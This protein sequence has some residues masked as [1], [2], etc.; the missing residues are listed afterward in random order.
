MDKFAT[1]TKTYKHLE[2]PQISLLWIISLLFIISAVMQM[3]YYWVVFSRFAFY[4]QQTTGKTS[5]PVS[6]VISAKNEFPN[7]KANLP[8]ILE[9]AYPEFEVVVVNDASDDETIFLLEDLKRDYTHLKIVNIEL[10]TLELLGLRSLKSRH[11]QAPLRVK[12]ICIE[13]GEVPE[14]S[15]RVVRSNDEPSSYI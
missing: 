9:Q 3:I 6:V 10:L 13:L 12:F 14:F 4:K 15:L 2:N 7:L 11:K 8:L 1:L 5:I